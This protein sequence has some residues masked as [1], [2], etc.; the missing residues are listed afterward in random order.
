MI[1]SSELDLNQIVKRGIMFKAASAKIAN[2]KETKKNIAKS[3]NV[4]ERTLQRY[5]NDL[6]FTSF[7]KNKAT[8]HF[9][10]SKCLYCSFVAKNK[11]GLG[12]HTRSKHLEELANQ[13][14]MSNNAMKKERDL[15]KKTRESKK[16]KETLGMG[17]EIVLKSKDYIN[18]EID[19]FLK[20]KNNH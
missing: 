12:A 17:D 19:E 20:T 10:P 14:T 3:L 1:M 16:N 6:N 15:P 13:P 5:A 9:E 4:S 7:K 2:P 11:S 8:T 18:E